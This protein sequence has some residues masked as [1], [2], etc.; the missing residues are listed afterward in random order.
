MVIATLIASSL[1]VAPF[2][3]LEI[4]KEGA[5][6]ALYV[7]NIVFGFKAQNYF[8]SNINKSPFLHTWSLGVEEQFY[9]VWPFVVYAALL[10]SRRTGIA[11]TQPGASHLC[12]H[13]G[14]LVRSER[15]PDE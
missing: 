1:I 15:G 3:M 6:A 14:D 11:R 7:S 12:D 10:M 9:L 5:S 2:D 8:A 13:F 4:S